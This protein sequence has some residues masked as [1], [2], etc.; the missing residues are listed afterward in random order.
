[1]QGIYKFLK[2]WKLPVAMVIGVVLYFFFGAVIPEA[3]VDGFYYVVSHILQ[4]ALIFCMLFLSFLKVDPK[5]LKPHRWHG[6]LLLTQGGLFVICSI[7]AL[8]FSDSPSAKILLE[9]AMLCFICPTA[10]ASA[11]IVQKL[12]GSL[13]GDVTY[14]VL[15]NLLVSALA[16]VFLTLVEPHSGLGFLTEFFMIMGKVFPLLLCPLFVALIVRHYAPAVMNWMLKIKDLAFYLWLVALALAITVTVKTIVESSIPLGLLSGLAVISAV[17]CAIQFSLGR[18]IGK[19]WQQPVKPCKEVENKEV[20]V[21]PVERSAITAGQAFGQKN[22][23]FIIWMGL[24]FLNPVTSV[25]G[26]FYSIWHNCVNSYQLY[27]KGK[28]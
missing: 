19:R 28:K 22:T 5:D 23:V 2:T 15:C 6:I 10:T 1:M 14:L 12:G 27:K 7:V 17:C 25:V 13:S 4:P 16:P 24:V 9:G 21:D 3:D 18:T 8:Y 26:G 20:Y 11:V